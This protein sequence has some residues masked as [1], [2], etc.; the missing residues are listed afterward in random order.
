V[1]LEGT[2]ET[3][4]L[5]ELIDMITYSSVT[6]VLNLF[7]QHP[8]GCLYFRD[9]N[10]YHCAASQGAVGVEALA[11]ML[12]IMQAGFSFV[13]D[14]IT[15]QVSLWGD[16]G[17][18]LQMAERLAYRWQGVRAAVPSL[19]LVPVLLVPFEV[20]RCRIGPSH[21]QVLDWIDGSNSLKA[22]VADL[23]WAEIDL[24]EAISQMLQD[25]L[26]EL[27]CGA[28]RPTAQPI[29]LPRG[30]FF[31]RL[32]SKP[33]EPASQSPDERPRASSEDLVLNILRG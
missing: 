3:I 8:L 14:A 19:D 16:I 30:G 9:G 22:I 10:L 20:A 1:K 11:G 29:E 24:A 13:G 18:H 33:E 15:E 5:S 23:G 32:R 6:G 2:L 7:D 25:N 17:Y 4:P 21:Y 12:E 31:E 26:I 27:R 28:Q